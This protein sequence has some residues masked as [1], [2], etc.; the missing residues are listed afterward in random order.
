MIN[1]NLKLV[2]TGLDIK[3]KRLYPIHLYKLTTY[4]K[5]V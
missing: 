4:D 2:N 3:I 1:N 5:Y